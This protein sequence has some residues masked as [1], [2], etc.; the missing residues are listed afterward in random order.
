MTGSNP[1]DQHVLGS[2]DDAVGWVTESALTGR[3]KEHLLAFIRKFPDLT[4]T[5][6]QEGLLEHFEQKDRVR[7]PAWLHETRR[8]LHF[9]EPL[10][11]VRFDDFDQYTPRADYL[12]EIWYTLDLG[13]MGEGQR[14]LFVEQAHCYPIGEWEETDRS[15]LA[16]DVKNTDDG[17]ILEFSSPDLM[18]NISEGKAADA[19]V[20]PAFD[21]YASMLS[22][23][24]AGRMPNGT[25]IEAR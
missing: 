7:L 8:V 4:F 22:R 15:Y 2:A 10:M 18:D 17:R 19:S 11:Q 23:V 3:D 24:V 6:D 20:R 25:V 1:R 16:V 9:V 12:D 14:S 13:Y 5:K 21:S